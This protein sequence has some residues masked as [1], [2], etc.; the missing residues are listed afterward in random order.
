MKGEVHQLRVLLQQQ[1]AQQL[2]GTVQLLE[3]PMLVVEGQ[4]PPTR[5]PA[6]EGTSGP[7]NK[8]M[9]AKPVIIGIQQRQQHVLDT[10]HAEPSA[11]AAD[12]LDASHEA[13]VGATAAPSAD[14]MVKDYAEAYSSMKATMEIRLR[15]ELQRANFM[16]VQHTQETDQ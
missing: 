12:P 7:D 3:Q 5:M 13:A 14:Q 16:Q 15:H 2:S 11:A 6:A 1:A 4:L 9:I 8:L 10:Q